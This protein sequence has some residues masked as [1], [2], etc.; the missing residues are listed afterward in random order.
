MTLG[1]GVSNR[2]FEF[3]AGSSDSKGMLRPNRASGWLSVK[4][5]GSAPTG[6]WLAIPI[7][8]HR[9]SLKLPSECL[10]ISENGHLDSE[11]LSPAGL[12]TGILSSAVL[13]KL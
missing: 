3:G 7:V 6:A 13:C 11:L 5:V 12:D 8:G 4:S 2:V 1:L 9:G 10:Q